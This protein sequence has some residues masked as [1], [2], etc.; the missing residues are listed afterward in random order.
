MADTHFDVQRQQTDAPA[1]QRESRPAASDPFRDMR[2]EMNRMFDR[3]LRGGFGLPSAWRD[4]GEQWPGEGAF[5]AAAPAIDFAEDDKAFHLTAELPGL[6]EQDV[7]L[8]LADDVLTIRGEKH[9]EKDEKDKNYH[10]SERRF[11]AFRRV[12]RLP[13]HVD[14][15]KIEAN[16]KNGIL[17]VTLPK[18]ADAMQRQKKIEVKGQ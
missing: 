17:T 12:I 13:Q 8:Q 5:N 6:S 3:F 4:E 1:R 18:T 7:D 11:G 15:D 9:E 14:R 10:W 16:F 2:R